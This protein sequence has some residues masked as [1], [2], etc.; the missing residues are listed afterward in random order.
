MLCLRPRLPQS[1]LDLKAAQ[2]T[3]ERERRERLADELL[4]NGQACKGVEGEWN[5]EKSLQ[6]QTEELK[7][8]KLH[9]EALEANLSDL[10]KKRQCDEEAL[11]VRGDFLLPSPVDLIGPHLF[12]EAMKYF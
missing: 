10:V 11:E 4:E 9:L 1:P 12:I 5:G 2:E 3:A 8:A 7:E 6:Q